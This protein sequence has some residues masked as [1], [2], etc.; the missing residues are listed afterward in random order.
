MTTTRVASHPPVDSHAMH[1]GAVLSALY[2]LGGHVDR[3][4]VVGCQP[5]SL[6]PVMALSATVAAAVDSAAE[7]ALDTASEVTLTGR[8]GR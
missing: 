1:P 7:L 3:V 5:E 6:E 8:K 2:A 4:L